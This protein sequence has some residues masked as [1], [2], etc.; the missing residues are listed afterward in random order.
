[1]RTPVANKPGKELFY[2]RVMA[3]PII[4]GWVSAIAATIF[5]MPAKRLFRLLF[6]ALY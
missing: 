4:F 2:I 5:K 3:L 6:G 1:M